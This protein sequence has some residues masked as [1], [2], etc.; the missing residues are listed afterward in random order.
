MK[1]SSHKTFRGPGGISI[2]RGAPRGWTGP[3]FLQ[4]APG[5]WFRHVDP[6]V[7][8]QR[9]EDEVLGRLDPQEVWDKLH[10]LVP[11]VEPV[12]LCWEKPPLRP[13]PQPG[14]V[15]P[16]RHQNWCHRRIVADW[17]QDELHVTVLELGQPECP[18][19]RLK[20]MPEQIGLFEDDD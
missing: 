17:F 20:G 8:Q 1:T 11:G 10:L 12:L 5:T 9:F 13:P 14:E 7:Y 3:R 19:T 6:W 2:A 15:V 16:A 18:R 4:L